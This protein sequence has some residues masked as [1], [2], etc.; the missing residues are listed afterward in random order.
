MRVKSHGFSRVAAG[1]WGIFSSCGVDDTS[2]PVFVQRHQES[3]LVT[4]NTTR[5]SL[6]LVRAIKTV[7]EV[8]REIHGTFLVA[9]VI[10]GFLSIFKKSQISSPFEALTPRASLGVKGM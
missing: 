4:R 8:S 5:I 3:C 1:T 10:L 7:I 6:R 2:K 9:I